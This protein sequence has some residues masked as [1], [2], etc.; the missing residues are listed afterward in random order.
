MGGSIPAHKMHL[1]AIGFVKASAQSEAL[2]KI[3]P[4]L[5]EEEISI[6]KRGRNAHSNTVPKNADIADYKRATGFECL[7][8][9]L[10]LRKELERINYIFK[11]ICDNN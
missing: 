3:L 5:T 10:Y 11:L 8:G 1:K 4:I 9:Y 7:F 6:Y 2:E